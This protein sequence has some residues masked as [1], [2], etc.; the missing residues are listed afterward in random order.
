MTLLV[1]MQVSTMQDQC[2]L[3]S[4][5]IVFEY[6][7]KVASSTAPHSLYALFSMCRHGLQASLDKHSRCRS[8]A[9]SAKYIFKQD[10][11][12]ILALAS[13]ETAKTLVVQ[14]PADRKFIR[15]KH[16]MG[17]AGDV[18]DMK[19][20]WGAQTC[21]D[22]EHVFDMR[23]HCLRL[24][25]TPPQAGKPCTEISLYTRTSKQNA[26]SVSTFICSPKTKPR[27]LWRK[28][29]AVDKLPGNVA[30]KCR[31]ATI[32]G[33][34]HDS[35]QNLF[36]Q[37]SSESCQTL[38]LFHKPTKHIIVKTVSPFGLDCIVYSISDCQA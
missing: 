28:Q 10:L 18:N 31:R 24:Q 17:W 33:L 3:D 30:H 12:Q 27:L 32:Q 14:V 35:V 37:K 34:H 8:V 25:L 6:P 11:K 5:K 7:R 1:S 22:S 19:V 4:E 2:V 20:V 21:E 9:S 23:S 15:D 29:N 16:V 38:T 26:M 13:S 36:N